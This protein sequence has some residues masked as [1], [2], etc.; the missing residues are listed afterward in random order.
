VGSECTIGARDSAA[1]IER[2]S[3]IIRDSSY[4]QKLGKT[5]RARVE[6]HFGFNQ[7]ARHFEQMCDQLIQQRSESSVV[8]IVDESEHREP[9]ADVA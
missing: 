7:T 8:Q 2:V 3:K 4:R 6:Q 1:Y 5:M 9:L